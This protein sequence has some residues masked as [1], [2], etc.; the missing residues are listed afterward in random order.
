MKMIIG[1]QPI[2]LCRSENR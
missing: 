1:W 2:Q